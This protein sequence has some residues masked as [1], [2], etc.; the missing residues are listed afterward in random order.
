MFVDQVEIEV[1]AG[2]GGSGAEA[3]R[4]ES[5]VPFGGPSGGDGGRGGNVVL[6]ADPHL[7]TL[8]DFQYKQHYKAERGQ[9]GQG[10]NRTGKSG[11]DLTLR[12]PVGTVVTD[13]ASDRILG[14]LLHEADT[15]VVA[16]GGRGGRGNAAFVTPTHRAPREWE[17]GEPGEER[18]IRL[19]LKL[20]ADVG[21]VGQPNAGKSTLLAAVSAANP[22]IAD[23]PFTTLAP[24]LGVVQLKGYR[25]FVLAD[26]PGIIEGAHD[27]R[28]L[29]LQFL[30][31]IERTRTLA[32]VV[33]ADSADPIA[34]YQL[35]RDEIK[36]YSKELSLKPHCIIISKMDLLPP[37]AHGP[38]L[39]SDTAWARLEVSAV[40]GLGIDALKE[41]LWTRV[42]EAIARE[43]A[44]KDGAEGGP[45]RHR[46]RGTEVDASPS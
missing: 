41:A 14:E 5:G 18:R 26:I 12:V 45:E 19:E 10:K 21:L 46:T 28:G 4:R 34:E 39:A 16:K 29:G 30:R 22:K 35:L 3:F 24:N 20:I 23:Y 40:T 33:P 6:H 9:H 17:P 2:T 32:Y 25:S 42:Q 27:G 43:R 38:E 31:H 37:D 1:A 13:V 8:L 44:G 11:S 7:S 15:L 36:S